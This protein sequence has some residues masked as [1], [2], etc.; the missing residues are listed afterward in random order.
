MYLALRDAVDAHLAD[1]LLDGW[2]RAH[3]EEALRAH[4]VDIPARPTKT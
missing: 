2:T 1:P 4:G 3:L